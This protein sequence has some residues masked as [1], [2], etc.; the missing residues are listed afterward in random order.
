[1]E[2]TTEVPR[3]SS[4]PR[5]LRPG[6]VWIAFDILAPMALL[7]LALWVGGR[8]FMSSTTDC[9]PA[10]GRATTEGRPDETS[11]DGSRRRTHS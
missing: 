7:Y 11:I 6:P 5:W 2:L 1:M 3:T 10:G 9:R 4:R 8:P